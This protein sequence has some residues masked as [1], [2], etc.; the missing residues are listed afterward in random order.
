M[1]LL[2]LLDATFSSSILIGYRIKQMK[3]KEGYETWLGAEGNK[4]HGGHASMESYHML[5]GDECRM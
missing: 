3:E 2:W 1:H 4:I 5:G